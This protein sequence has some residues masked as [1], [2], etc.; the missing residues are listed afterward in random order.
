MCPASAPK[1]TAIDRESS[2]VNIASA[3]RLGSGPALGPKYPS[4]LRSCNGLLV[5]FPGLPSSGRRHIQQHSSHAVI[6][7]TEAGLRLVEIEG[8]GT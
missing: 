8:E 3:G 4:T 6:T 2:P 1:G 5:N 7:G